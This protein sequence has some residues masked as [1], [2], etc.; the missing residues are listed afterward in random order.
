EARRGGAGLVRQDFDIGRTAVVIDRD[1]HVFPAGAD[2]AALVRMHPVTDAQDA[3][4]GL[5]VE[6][7]EF[8]W[9]RALIS[10]RERWWGQTGQAIEANA[11]QHGRD[12]RAR[13]LQ[14]RRDRPRGASCVAGR[15]NRW[16]GFGW[17]AARLPMRPGGR[18]LERGPPTQAVP[19]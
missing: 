17:G 13:H 10:L 12:G 2:T 8:A 11:D 6:G 18:V 9:P 4:Q 1:V 16:D 3:P 15:D 19:P 14:L 5:H 7:H